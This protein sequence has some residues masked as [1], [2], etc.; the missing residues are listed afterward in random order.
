M[1]LQTTC[2][3]IG[4]MTTVFDDVNECPLDCD[5]LLPDYLPEIAVI[6]KCRMKPTVQSHQVSGDRVV[7]DGTVHLQLLY[8]DEE[9]RCVRSYECS[10][11][12]SSVFTVKEL[13]SSDNILLSARTNYVNCRAVGPRRVDIHG[14]FGV[15]LIVQAETSVEIITQAETEGLQTR[16]CTVAGSLPAGSARKAVSLNEV[17]ELPTAAESVMRCEPCAVVTDCRQMPGKAVVKGDVLMQTACISDAA[18][19]TVAHS[20]HRIPF[21]LILDVDGLSEDRLCDCCAEILHCEVHLMQDPNGENRLL[22][23]SVKVLVTVCCYRSEEYRLIT[24][25]YHTA[26]PLKTETCQVT[27]DHLQF[28]RSDEVT[29][30]LSQELPQSDTAGIID[31]WCEPLPATCQADAEH[32]VLSG[33]LLIA[34]LTRDGEG[35]VA[36]YE[37]SAAYEATLP[38]NSA[39]GEVCVLPLEVTYTQNGATMDVRV[40]MAVHRVGSRQ[41][42][43]TAITGMT[44]DDSAPYTE[45]GLLAGCCLKVCY[46]SAGD[47]VWELAQR[48]HTSPEAIRLENDIAGDVVEKDALLFIPL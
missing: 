32:T 8:L 33:Q 21:S 10:Q 13:K 12:F 38:D 31:V 29:V 44:A 20:T 25:A 1:E 37:R 15:R 3:R 42:T 28:V 7:A 9:R 34:M 46:A 30:S 5:F 18:S 47:S 35:C 43:Y 22:S 45:S 36:Y 2:G 26:Y 23:V 14:A 6:L 19:G 4:T 24:D 11:P 27:I 40:S 41:E 17:L 48:E 16:G 39:C